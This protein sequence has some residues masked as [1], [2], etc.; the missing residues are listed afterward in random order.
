[1]MERAVV[2]EKSIEK[3]PLSPLTDINTIVIQ[4][5]YTYSHGCLPVRLSLNISTIKI[6][7]TQT[8]RF[9][10]LIRKKPVHLLPFRRENLE[11]NN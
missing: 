3:V 8:T 9:S 6:A 11:S 4:T 7:K 5:T 10:I 1:M 2:C